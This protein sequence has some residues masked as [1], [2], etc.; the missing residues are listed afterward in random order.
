MGK[1]ASLSVAVNDLTKKGYTYNF[2]MKEEC[3]ECQE[4]QCQLQPEDFE[5]EEKHRFQE[6]S[7]VDNESVLY[8]ISSTD[9]KIKGL[10]VNAYGVYADYA[11]FKLIQK[12]N[13]PER[14][15]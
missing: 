5:I 2:N 9:G 13:M 11:S 1:Y 3:I 8:A 4:N 14:K 6:M 15:C 10:L 12:L 7:D